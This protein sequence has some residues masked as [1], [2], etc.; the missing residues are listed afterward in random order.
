V[1]F[2][3]GVLGSSPSALTKQN[4]SLT[5]KIKARRFPDNP[6]WEAIG[7]LVL[8]LFGCGVALGALLREGMSM[9]PLMV[10]GIA[11]GLPALFFLIAVLVIARI[12]SFGDPGSMY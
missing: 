3:H 12:N 4:Q 1:T 9:T 2:N 11:V 5:S 10:I 7:K 6:I 8:L